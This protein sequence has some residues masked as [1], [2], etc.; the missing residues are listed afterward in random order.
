MDINEALRTIRANVAGAQRQM[1]A[2][3]D[4]PRFC[5]VDNGT[6]SP[7][8][9]AALLRPSFGDGR[10]AV[11]QPLP[12]AILVAARGHVPPRRRRR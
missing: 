11:F 9:V 10:A 7:S 8:I 3:T 1:D 2:D 12:I 6:V 5:V 4:H